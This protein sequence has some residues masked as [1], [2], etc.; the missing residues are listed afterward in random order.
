MTLEGP[1]TLNFLIPKIS[2]PNIADAQM[3]EL[4]VIPVPF[5]IGS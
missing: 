2:N 1:L 5:N 3:C 4:A